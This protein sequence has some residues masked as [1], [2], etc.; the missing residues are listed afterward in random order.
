MSIRLWAI[1]KVRHQAS[2]IWSCHLHTVQLPLTWEWVAIAGYLHSISLTL[3]ISAL[4]SFPLISKRNQPSPQVDSIQYRM[5]QCACGQGQKLLLEI[6]TKNWSTSINFGNGNY[7]PSCQISPLQLH[8]LHQLHF[9][10]FPPWSLEFARLVLA[11]PTLP[12]WPP[13]SF[14]QLMHVHKAD[15]V[16]L[17]YIFSHCAVS[18]LLLRCQDDEMDE[19]GMNNLSREQK[20]RT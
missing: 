4:S 13:T 14:L 15:F 17:L 16:F 2:W 20:E 7:K 6:I 12:I 10:W 19:S 5:I 1:V 9:H 3:Y 11:C 8:A 18:L